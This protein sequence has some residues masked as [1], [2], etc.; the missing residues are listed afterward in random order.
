MTR[1]LRS[2]LFAHVV[3]ACSIALAQTPASDAPEA[4]PLQAL[5]VLS[6]ARSVSSGCNPWKMNA[7]S[8]DLSFGQRACMGLSELASPALMIEVGAVAGFAQ[9]RNS[10][11][12][13]KGDSEDFSTRV[14]HLYARRTAHVT[15]ETIV[16]YLHHEDPRLH[17]SGEKGAWRRTRAAFLSVMESPGQD[18]NARVALAPLAGSLGSGLTSM[19]F[20]ERHTSLGDGLERSGI[21]YSHYFVRALVHEFSP[22]L[23]SMAPSFVRKY[24]AP[25][26]PGN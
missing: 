6:A 19:A 24:H 4:S 14:E 20:N 16:D 12:S 7:F 8:T 22:E 21:V 5:P 26:T 11:R 25:S 2:I 13:G 23:W 15:A 10:L 18:G 1:R 3:A 17:S 9:W